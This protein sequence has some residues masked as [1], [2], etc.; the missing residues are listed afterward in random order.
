MD[1]PKPHYEYFPIFLDPRLWNKIL[2]KMFDS[3]LDNLDHQ[4]M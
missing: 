3:S 1:G 2:Q 4:Q